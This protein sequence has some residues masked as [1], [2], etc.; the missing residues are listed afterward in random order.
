MN[1][2]LNDWLTGIDGKTFDPSRA[3][4]LAAVGVFLFLSIWAVVH[5]KQTWSAQDFGIGLGAILA[6]GGAGV[7]LKSKTEPKVSNQE[8]T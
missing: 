1:Q 3:C 8:D 7:A 4:L 5:L 2:L 6:G